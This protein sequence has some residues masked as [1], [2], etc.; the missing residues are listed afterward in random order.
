MQAAECDAVSAFKQQLGI[1]S[2][3][4]E[5]FG[6]IAEVGLQSP[7]PPRWTSHTDTSSGYVYYVDHDHQV[8]SWENP[9]VPFLRRVVEIG[10]NYLRQPQENF[11]EDQKGLLWHQ[12]K[13]DLDMWH[14]PFSDEEGRQ[15]FVNSTEG[16]SSWQDPRVDAQYIFELESG[17]LTSLEEVLNQPGT[18]DTPGFGPSPDPWRTAE[19][20]EVLTLEGPGRQPGT[21]GSNSSARPG[22]RSQLLSQ[23][24]MNAKEEHRSTLQK[25]TGAAGR[26]HVLQQDDLEAQRLQVSRKVTARKQRQQMLAAQAAPPVRI[27]QDPALSAS[28][29][30]RP[31][32]ALG[33]LESAE[34][35]APPSLG[36]LPPPPPPRQM[37]ELQ[38]VPPDSARSNSKD[39]PAMGQEVFRPPAVPPSPLTGGHV[40]VPLDLGQRLKRP[41]AEKAEP[42]QGASL[43]SMELRTESSEK[44]G[45]ES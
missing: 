10:R 17:L 6:W 43:G 40:A 21:A 2:S 22:L 19:G 31:A 38:P 23:A 7:L 15:Y 35:Q 45:E 26:L 3:E 44:P 41:A 29:G 5:Q 27:P 42:F 39:A 36:V 18:P 8:S 24:Q 30:S 14:G 12:H 34:G 4:D 28:V 16:I 9:L 11:F 32:L 1:H 13:H 20:A 33:S 25:M 37:G